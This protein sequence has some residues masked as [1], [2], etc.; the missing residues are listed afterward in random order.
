MVWLVDLY[1]FASTYYILP[2][3]HDTLQALAV[4]T[5]IGA[6]L[7]NY[8]ILNKAFS[9]EDTSLLSKYLKDLYDLNWSPAIATKFRAEKNENLHPKLVKIFIRNL[10]EDLETSQLEKETLSQK[11]N[12]TKAQQA[13]RDQEII[14]ERAATSRALTEVTAQ[15][16]QIAETEKALADA[17]AR[18]AELERENRSFHGQKREREGD[19]DVVPEEPAIGNDGQT[20]ASET[21]GQSLKKARRTLRPRTSGASSMV[22]S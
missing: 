10:V 15:T 22:P 21:F 9:A 3:K 16:T 20:D 19:G 7:P 2:L 12:A 14:E 8:K 17:R 5:E 13:R 1:I 6:E 4:V 11:M 18:I